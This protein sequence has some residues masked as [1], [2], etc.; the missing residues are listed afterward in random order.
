MILLIFG[1]LIVVYVLFVLVRQFFS[2]LRHLPEPQGGIPILGHTLKISSSEDQVALQN[3][4]A[5]QFM[6]MGLY[7]T[8]SL[9]CEFKKTNLIPVF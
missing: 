2:P 6:E 4:W 7:K 9:F 8:R 1:A 3:K 5:E